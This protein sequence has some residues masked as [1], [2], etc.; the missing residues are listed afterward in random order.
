MSAFEKIAAGLT[1]AINFAEGNAD[2]ANYVVHVPASVDVKAIRKRSRL[3]QEAF[4]ARY[5]F[6]IGRL[7]DW[8]Q[9]RS[10]P[11]TPSRLLL[12]VIDKEPEAIER[13]TAEARLSA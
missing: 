1:D 2:L 7:R 6:T 9:N 8:E 3:S 10:T 11:D 4:A 5:G 13:A 12:T